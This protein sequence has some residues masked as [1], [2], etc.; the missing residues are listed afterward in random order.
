[1]FGDRVVCY[2]SMAWRCIRTTLLF[3]YSQ[4]NDKVEDAFAW[5]GL[6]IG[7]YPKY[8]LLV[9]VTILFGLSFGLA[10][11]EI[12]K[13][14]QNLWTPIGS[15]SERERVFIDEYWSASGY[16]TIT[17]IGADIDDTKK[18][19]LH[20]SYFQEWLEIILTI[21]N[22]SPDFDWT[23]TW[24][25]RTTGETEERTD[26]WNLVPGLFEI[27]S[28]ATK[29][30]YCYFVQTNGKHHCQRTRFRRWPANK[31]TGMLLGS[32]RSAAHL[33]PLPSKR[34][35]SFRVI[36]RRLSTASPKAD[37]ICRMRTTWLRQF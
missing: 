21:H 36:W 4:L 15:P 10:E 13:D 37:S 33:L 1:M 26:R 19:I 2:I 8:F 27:V 5:L 17:M 20:E 22:D 31:L 14:I 3:C 30:L 18:D 35:S 34:S 24:T 9:V 23:Y 29:C 32:S 16:G 25:N 12:E 28:I 7:K 11:F 6:T